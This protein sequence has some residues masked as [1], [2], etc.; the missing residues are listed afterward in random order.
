MDDRQLFDRLRAGD[1]AA[2]D[3]AYERFHEPIY[4][5]LVRATRDVAVAEE[6]HQ[7]TWL[8]FARNACSLPAETELRAWLFTVARNLFRSHR[9]RRLLGGGL[10]QALGWWAR[11]EESPS[12]HELAAAS[13]AERRLEAAIAG[14]PAPLREVLLLVAVEGLPPQEVGRVLGLSPAAVRKRLERARARVAASLEE[15]P[16]VA[17]VGEETP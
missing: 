9:R 3:Q 12:P 6:L 5:F 13:E 4:R 17:P 16:G 14:L 2:F 1:A 8:R 15:R 11:P 10:L 7:E